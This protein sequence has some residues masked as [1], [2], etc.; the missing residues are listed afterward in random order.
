MA[1]ACSKAT[2]NAIFPHLFQG[3]PFKKVFLPLLLYSAVV[4]LIV[5]SC[6]LASHAKRSTAFPPFF[7]FLAS[8]LLK[9]T[10]D[11]YYVML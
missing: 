1:A 2:P 5:T 10:C 9:V 4:Q 11:M 7:F 3:M 8:K 6:A